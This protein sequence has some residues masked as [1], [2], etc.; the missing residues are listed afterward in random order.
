MREI[1]SDKHNNKM[2][3]FTIG[4]TIHITTL[5]KYPNVDARSPKFDGTFDQACEYVR[6]H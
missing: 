1:V 5:K 4:E 3:V 6:T 2:V